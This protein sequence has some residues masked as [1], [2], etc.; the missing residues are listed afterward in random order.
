MEIKDSRLKTRSTRSGILVGVISYDHQSLQ[1][2]KRQ[3]DA[4]VESLSSEPTAM[5]ATC[6]GSL[7]K[8]AATNYFWQT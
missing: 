3:G 7:Q 6:S 8:G 2:D 1:K 4:V 5:E